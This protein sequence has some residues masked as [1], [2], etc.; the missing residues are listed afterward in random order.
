MLRYYV[1]TSRSL[2]CLKRQFHSLPK[3]DTTVIINTTLDWY[4]EQAKQYC[5]DNEID[6]AITRS[7]GHPGRGKNSVLQH[8]LASNYHFMV[9]IDGDDFMQPNGVNLYRAVAESSNPPDGI[10][11]MHSMSYSGGM[12]IE[13]MWFP[14]PWHK[15]YAERARK[16]EADFPQLKQTLRREWNKRKETKKL[17][18]VHFSQNKKWNYPG[19]S[20]D[21][22][23]CARLIFWSRK[24]AELVTFRED[25]M[26]G[27]DT[28]VNMQVREL[29]FR[30]EIELQKIKD[31]EHR[32]YIYDLTNS[33]IVKRLRNKIDWTWVAPLND[34]IAEESKK[35]TMTSEFRLAPVAIEIERTP[36]IK[37]GEV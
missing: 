30:G 32:T 26:I 25:L 13:Q 31:S 6:Y 5:I 7:N 37:L 22:L 9:Q 21:P 17:M 14:D 10:Q 15:D 8:F 20:R 36:D 24:L 3:E 19:E 2:K 33:G 12:K 1:L 18:S 4:R 16:V 27:E 34:A 35:W 23:D 11:I 29:A 28:L